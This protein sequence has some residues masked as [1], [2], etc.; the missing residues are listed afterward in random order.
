MATD[1]SHRRATLA[2]AHA[3]AVSMRPED[4]EELAA[5]GSTPRE[6]L[7]R[8]LASSLCC[9]AL[10]LR[11]RL[12]CMWGVTAAPGWGGSVLGGVRCGWMLASSL[13]DDG[14]YHRAF[15]RESKLVSAAAVQTW[16]PLTNAVDERNGRAR[17]WLTRLGARWTQPLDVNG[18]P[19]LVF[20][21]GG[22]HV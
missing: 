14:R 10:E 11:G 9:F 21:L 2:D 5:W 16:G 12:A 4:V 6:S 8:G 19:F 1:V 20:V 13:V 17:A 3:L 18:H 22:I 15:W 7:E